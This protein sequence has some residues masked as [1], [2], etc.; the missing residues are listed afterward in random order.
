MKIRSRLFTA[1]LIMTIFPIVLM[2]ICVHIILGKQAEFVT[3]SYN[4]SESLYKNY[5]VLVN[6]VAYLYNISQ[7]DYKALNRIA[8]K[9]PDKFLNMLNEIL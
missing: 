8:N 9:N 6:P 7:K 2:F 3:D 1:F 5:D 4:I